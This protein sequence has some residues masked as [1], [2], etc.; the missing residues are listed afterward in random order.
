[1]QIEVHDAITGD[2]TRPEPV[3]GGDLS[4]LRVEVG[5][6][7]GVPAQTPRMVAQVVEHRR[8]VDALHHHVETVVGDLE[9][10]RRGVPTGAYVLHHLGFPFLRAALAAATQYPSGSGGEDV[11][12]ASGRYRATPS[13]WP[14]YAPAD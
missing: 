10:L 4:Q 5:Q 8:P 7:E 3:G 14:N 9:H 12:V 6:H 2:G 1:M 13:P 11:G